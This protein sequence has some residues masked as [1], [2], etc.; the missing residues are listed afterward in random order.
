MKK[1]KT[2]VTDCFLLLPAF[3]FFNM[4][5]SHKRTTMVSDDAAG[6]DLA[7]AR[8]RLK[9]HQTA[10][11]N[12]QNAQNSQNLQVRDLSDRTFSGQNLSMMG[13]NLS[14]RNLSSQSFMTDEE[15][16][17]VYPTNHGGS[18]AEGERKAPFE[19]VVRRN[20]M[21]IENLK[22]YKNVI[23]FVPRSSYF[24]IHR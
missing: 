13:Q 20:Q 18:D 6:A 10:S 7:E 2:D 11:E 4:D 15:S 16:S 5:R 17:A 23:F 22:L 14:S 12:V 8:N 1:R 21:E 19:A 3:D 9:L 24:V